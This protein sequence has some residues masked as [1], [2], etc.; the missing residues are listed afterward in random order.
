MEWLLLGGGAVITGSYLLNELD[1]IYQKHIGIP[2]SNYIKKE[3]NDSFERE[4][5]ELR[6]LQMDRK[7]ERYNHHQH[8]RNQYN[9]KPKYN[10]QFINNS[11]NV[12]DVIYVNHYKAASKAQA[13]TWAKKKIENHL[14]DGEV[15]NKLSTK[16]LTL[17]VTNSIE[18]IES[19][20]DE[21]FIVLHS[22]NDYIVLDR[23]NIENNQIKISDLFQCDVIEDIQCKWY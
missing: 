22:N 19:E 5:E 16:K 7:K 4:Q 9:L 6:Q 20:W 11:E 18:I 12:W 3:K 15:M 23:N 13:M 17:G 8:L 2:V 14:F 10:V 1:N 21:Y